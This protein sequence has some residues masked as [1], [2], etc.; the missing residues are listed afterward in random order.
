[1]QLCAWPSNYKVLLLKYQQYTEN[2]N[3]CIEQIIKRC[4]TRP[5]GGDILA[6]FIIFAQAHN[7]Y[8]FICEAE[9]C[10]AKRCANME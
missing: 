7:N 2:A 6:I 9:R 3:I 4:T 10:K 5:S 1:M 8:H